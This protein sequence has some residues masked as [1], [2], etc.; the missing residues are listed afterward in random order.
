MGDDQGA[1]DFEISEV[2]LISEGGGGAY[3]SE[4]EAASHGSDD[5][6]DGGDDEA[7][8]PTAAAASSKEKKKEK[9]KAK[10]LEVKAKKKRK[11]EEEEADADSSSP[12]T[13]VTEQLVLFGKCQPRS[14][15]DGSRAIQLDESAFLDPSTYNGKHAAEWKSCPFVM[16]VAAAMHSLEGLHSRSDEMGC[17]RVLVL[18]A[19]ALRASHTLNN[20]SSLLKCA[21]AKVWSK[22]FKVPAQ[23]EALG[24]KVYPVAVG[25]PARVAKLF[26]IGALDARKL[27]LVIVDT[28]RNQKDFHL[29]SLPDTQQD[30]YALIEKYL[31][32]RIKEGACRISLVAQSERFST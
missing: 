2:A 25:T 24:K 18:S 30:T 17:P 12:S 8:S 31:L 22:H 9:R 11:L 15:E 14:K 19:G 1:E 27:E 4:E 6:S 7:G 23:V 29:L 26:E 20:M 10:L 3:A 28:A 32:P 21:H 5:D 16:A 13:S